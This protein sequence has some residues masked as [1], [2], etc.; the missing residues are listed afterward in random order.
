M[1]LIFNLIF[2]NALYAKAFP[3]MIR[4]HYVNCGACHVNPAGGGVLN[5]YGRTIS[6]EV[7]STWG[8]EKEA[9]AFYGVDPEKIGDWLNV[10][11][12]MRSLQVHQENKM[13]KRGRYFWMQ[14]NLD[15]AVTLDKWTGYLTLGQVNTESQSLRLISPNYFLA[16]QF[17]DEVSLRVGRYVP[18]FG[19]RLPQHQYLIKQN[20]AL[21]PGT[22]RDATDL[23]YNGEKWNFMLGYSRSL[24]NSAV[25]D[26]EKAF[27]AQIQAT[28]KDS[29]KFGLSIW[30]GDADA[31]KKTMLG[32]HGVFG[33]TER[34]YTLAEIDQVSQVVKST[35]IETKSIYQLLK[36]GY[37][38][39]KGTHVQIVQEWGKP[40][41]QN[42]VEIQSIGLGVIWYPRPHFEFESLW[43]K[44]RTVGTS[45]EFEDFAYLLTHFYF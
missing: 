28:L 15:I 31:Y 14:G 10:G 40:N 30:S 24:L 44:R 2:L 17:L 6:Y 9:R 38:F 8:H 35:N 42:S 20:L 32:L 22:D 45:D 21:G 36:L 41:T 16:Y 23:Q 29:H 11:G 26:E 1:F 37:E 3:E 27:H 19:I 33:W 25:R 13:V 12:D 43:T 5:A 7:L 39:Y 34:L 18:L 4:H